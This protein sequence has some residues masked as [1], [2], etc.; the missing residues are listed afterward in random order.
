VKHW[1]LAA[2]DTSQDQD[3]GE[4]GNTQ[5]RDTRYEQRCFMPRFS[6]IMR[7]DCI[8]NGGTKDRSWHSLIVMLN[9]ILIAESAVGP[10]Q[11]EA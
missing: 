4:S 7:P 2:T 8:W 5:P 10:H 1:R 3:E 11:S 9:L 6:P